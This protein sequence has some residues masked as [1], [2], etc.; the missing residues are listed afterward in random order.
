M[1]IESCLKRMIQQESIKEKQ[2]ILLSLS[3]H[4]N[5]LTP[6]S[7]ND[8]DVTPLIVL[9]GG[10]IVL[11]YND[12]DIEDYSRFISDYESILIVLQLI[13]KEGKDLFLY[14][15]QDDLMTPAELFQHIETAIQNNDYDSFMEFTNQLKKKR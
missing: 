12:E 5:Q 3:K 2:Y 15:N 13:F 7:E 6:V 1:D 14:I 8:R 10:N 4:S 9:S 11:Y